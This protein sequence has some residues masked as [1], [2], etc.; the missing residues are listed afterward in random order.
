VAYLLNEAIAN[1]YYEPL[2]EEEKEAQK[3]DIEALIGTS[4]RGSWLTC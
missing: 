2:S 1:H 3:K 4:P